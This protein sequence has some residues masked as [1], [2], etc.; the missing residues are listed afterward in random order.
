MGSAGTLVATPQGQDVIPAHP[1]EQVDATAA[2]DTFDGAFLAALLRGED[3]ATAARTANVAAALSTLGH[4][5]VAPM[6][7]ADD[8]HR[9]L[10]TGT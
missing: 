4:G 3:A 9:A 2:G 10:G 7:T 6:P 5:A 1:V 8:V